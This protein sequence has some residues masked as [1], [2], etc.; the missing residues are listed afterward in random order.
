MTI[1]D[2]TQ[3]EKI[4]F[5]VGIGIIQTEPVRNFYNTSDATATSSDIIVGKTAYSRYGIIN[6]ELDLQ[7]EKETSYQEGYNDIISEQSDANIT[8]NKVVNGY[9]GYAANNQKIVG[10]LDAITSIDVAEQGI[11]FH[12]WSTEILPGYYNFINVTDL[13]NMFN[14]CPN[15]TK[16]ENS[17]NCESVQNFGQF[18]IDCPNITEFGMYNIKNSISLSPYNN[19]LP[20]TVKS[21]IDGLMYTDKSPII[22]L[23]INLQKVDENTIASA[24]N[25]GWLVAGV[26]L[27]QV[28][29]PI[30]NNEWQLSTQ[31]T[32]LDTELYDGIYESSSNYQVNSGKATMSIEID[33]YTDFT[34]YICSYG[35]ANYDYIWVGKLDQIPSTDNDAYATTKGTP[36]EPTSLANFTEVKFSNLDA[37]KHTINIVYKKDGSGNSFNDRG[38]VIIPKYQ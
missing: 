13:N 32:W 6:G 14:N 28:F 36:K 15:L 1:Y 18:F 25:K 30:L 2:K 5:P 37:R 35:E 23:G 8:P 17:M 21:V 29:T 22:S 7:N 10:T 33:G 20:S 38:Y 3:D 31:Y 9:I 27:P 16:I 26:N 24:V 34:F 19:L 11:K 12:N 4:Q